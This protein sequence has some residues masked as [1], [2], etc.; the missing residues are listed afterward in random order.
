M[1]TESLRCLQWNCRGLLRK[2]SVLINLINELECN[3]ILLNETHLDNTMYFNLPNHSIFRKDHRSNPTAF[4]LNVPVDIQHISCQLRTS[5]GVI[6]VVSVYIHPQ[7]NVSENGL[8]HFLRSVPKPCVIGGDFNAKHPLWGNNTENQRGRCLYDA[9]E[10]ENLVVLNNGDATRYDANNSWSA[11]DITIVSPELSLMFDWEVQENPTG[12]DHFPIVFG[13]LG[14][15]VDQRRSK[16][17]WRKI[18]WE[19]YA[20]KIED[21][22]AA[23]TGSLDPIRFFRLVWNALT[24][25][26]PNPSP[27]TDKMKIPQ[28]Y[29]DDELAAAKQETRTAFKAW[30]R[31]LTQDAYDDYNAAELRFRKMIKE[32]KTAS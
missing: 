32:K 7:A 9:L 22:L 19:T 23:Y 8:A 11:I 12:S 6:T 21:D 14:T 29:W 25:S 20:K 10:S 24:H 13:L 1:N 31:M 15:T 17:N 30:K 2:R 16:L 3:I 27:R 5:L 26:A 18:N 28:P 4:Q